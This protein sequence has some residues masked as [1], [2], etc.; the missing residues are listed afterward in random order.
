MRAVKLAKKTAGEEA[1]IALSILIFQKFTAGISLPLFYKRIGQTLC[2][3]VCSNR[4]EQ[5]RQCSAALPL[6]LFT[7]KA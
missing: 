5:G 6:N 1:L 4:P 7:F 3:P 2:R